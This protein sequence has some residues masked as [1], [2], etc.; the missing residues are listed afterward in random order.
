MRI[1][2]LTLAEMTPEQRSAV[3]EA[4]AGRRGRVPAP[5]RAWLHS[6]TIGSHAQRLGEA[7]RYD[8]A[9]DRRLRELATLVTARFWTAHYEWYA[10]KI[11]ALEAGLEPAIINAIARGERPV[12]TQPKDL[13]VYDYATSVHETRQIS[14]ALHEAA[15]RELG[16]EQTVELVCLLGYYTLVSMTLN[17]FAFELPTGAVSELADQARHAGGPTMRSF[18]NDP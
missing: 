14:P 17:V 15:L 12:L 5:L 11:E 7:L 13:V 3:N 2:D 16:I 8:A 18:S 1:P 10:R 6:P 4:S 9:L